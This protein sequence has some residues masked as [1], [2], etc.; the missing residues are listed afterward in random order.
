MFGGS[1][2]DFLECQAEIR[3]LLAK[4]AIKPCSPKKGQFISSYFLVP[5]S[6]GTKRFV[7]NLKRLNNH[8]RCN[9]F[10]MENYRTACNLLAEGDYMCK[11]DLKD[12]YFLVPLCA[13]SRK[14]F[15]FIFHDI[16]YEFTCL[17][18]G[19]NV[20]PYVFT[21]LMKVP[22]STLRNDGYRSVIYL[23][24]ILIFGSNYASCAENVNKTMHL[25]TSL[26]FIIN[27]NKSIL[28][29][30]T[31]CPF[32][33]FV[34]DSQKMRLEIPEDKRSRVS[35]L[36][37][38]FTSRKSCSIRSFASLVGTLVSVC[39]ALEYGWLYTK[40]ME[41][42]KY[43]AL[44][45]SGYD[46]DAKMI[47]PS[48]IGKDLL[49][50]KNN[51]MFG[52]KTLRHLTYEHEIFS[53]ASLKGWG[54]F[55]NGDCASGSWK[56]LESCLHINE[57]ELLAAYF[58]LR[59]FVAKLCGVRIIM[60]I[61]N[62]TAISYINK[63]G[64]TH[65]PRLSRIAKSIWQWCETRSITLYASYIPSKDNVEA[66]TLSRTANL[67]TEWELSP[68]VF[69]EIVEKFGIPEIDLFA[70]RSN[71]KLGRYVAWHKDPEAE[72]MD[73]FSI[74]WR[75]LYFYAFPP[76]AILL[77][78]L[79]KLVTDRAVGIV[80]AP[81][82]PSQP[83]FPMFRS[84]LIRGPLIWEPSNNLLLSPCRSVQHPLARQ[85]SLIVGVLSG[86]PSSKE[87]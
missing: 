33:G 53:D 31:T 6:D 20:A 28:T 70:S 56:P 13:K 42:E 61:D 54:A 26:G 25:L 15:R 68:L 29:P 52:S 3:R 38:Q 47:V 17:P 14:Y 48:S 5:K 76:F 11:L 32:L 4:G 60:R 85:L 62:T 16:L 41:Y 50:W 57:L 46:F 69:S 49:W 27:N 34:L 81:L 21:K 65:S 78:T 37:S 35:S 74:N 83:W 51:I 19:L 67:D 30:A 9:H 36:L 77:R 79:R 87:S 39:P 12:A 66:D 2:A 72:S 73:A 82:W 64:G 23:D 59:C 58:A 86:D 71:A 40:L 45:V 75:S 18:F 22:I 63:M 1:K 24:D 80:V 43:V 55:H 10:K 44:L 8:I 7:L 84:L